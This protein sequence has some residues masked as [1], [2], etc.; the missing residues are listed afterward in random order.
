MSKI[1][2]SFL[3][4]LYK[5]KKS[6]EEYVKKLIY[7]D[8]GICDNVF[9]E[10]P[11]YYEI[12]ISLLKRHPDFDIKTN[13][14]ISLKIT[15]D[16]LNKKALKIIIV[17]SDDTETDISWRNAINGKGSDVKSDL[18][19]AL[20]SSI[21]NQIWDFKRTHENICETCGSTQNIHIDHENYFEKIVIDFTN[22]RTDIP[23]DFDDMKDNTHRKCFKLSDEKFRKD[24]I[25]FH[26]KNAVLRVLCE[27]CNLKRPKYKK[28]N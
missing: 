24:W 10:K 14:M 26:Q 16:A 22:G 6:F 11:K 18:N 25:V 8:I 13:K 20:R 7:E 27:K 21:E 15:H 5:T 23:T 9:E 1:Q 12:L 3:G 28:Q 4:T 2:I 17:N 19:S